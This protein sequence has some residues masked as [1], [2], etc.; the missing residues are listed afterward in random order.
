MT[1]TRNLNTRYNYICEQKLNTK[2]IDYLTNTVYAEQKN[3]V[4]MF[5][6]GSNPSIMNGHHFSYNYIDME[7]KLRGIRST[8]MVGISFDP[9]LQQKTFSTTKLF[10]NHLKEQNTVPSSFIHDS[11]QRYGFHNI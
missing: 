1:S 2:T 3:P 6:L 5:D 10:E 4:H 7:S 9:E 11:D 8:N